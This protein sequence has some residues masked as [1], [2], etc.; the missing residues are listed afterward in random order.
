[1]QRISFEKTLT[2]DKIL[3]NLNPAHRD[4]FKHYFRS[5]HLY[6]GM[7]L[8]MQ[9]DKAD[10][11]YFIESGEISIV[12]EQQGGK[13]ERLRKVCAGNVI[14]EM[15]LYNQTRRVAS[16]VAITDCVLQE[17]TQDM[18]IKMEEDDQ[19]L[20]IALDRFIINI[21]SERLTFLD[22]QIRQLL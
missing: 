6:R 22:K 9:G 4:K 14:G 3:P 21:I 7:Y 20:V 16:A 11:L 17:L 1:M 13:V 18:L 10:S 12:L 8:F 2:I 15:G 5:K 19:Q